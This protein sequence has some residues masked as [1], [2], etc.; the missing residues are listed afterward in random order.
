VYIFLSAATEWIGPSKRSWGA[1]VSQL[2]GAVGQCVIAAM[3]YFIR[4]W[5]LAQL[6]T[7]APIAVAVIYIW[8]ALT[9]FCIAFDHFICKWLTIWSVT[10]SVPVRFIPESAR[11]LLS[12]G[13]TEEAKQLI[14]KAAAINKRT[15]PDSLLNNV[16]VSLFFK[17]LFNSIR[18]ILYSPISQT[19][20][21]NYDRRPAHQTGGIRHS[22]VQ[23]TLWDVKSQGLRGG[24]RFNNVWW[25][26]VNSAI[27]SESE[28]ETGAQ[29]I[30]KCPRAAYK[31]IAAAL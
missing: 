18:Y 10:S 25:R 4:D 9:T 14:V 8:C 15:V 7:A 6:I 16:H 20:L 29:C 27:M 2:F 12:R 28:E 3:I 19:I 17:P 5:R 21:A 30:L 24:S 31:P 1:C 22:Q 13:R 11:W 26:D 23:W